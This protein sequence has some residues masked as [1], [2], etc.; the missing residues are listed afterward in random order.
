MHRSQ[1]GLL[2][3]TQ[4]R[5]AWQPEHRE[6]RVVVEQRLHHGGRLLL[7]VHDRVVESAVRLD[8]ADAGPGDARERIEGTDL[9]DHVLGQRLRLDVDEPAPEAGQVAITH[10]RTDGHVGGDGAV[11]DPTHDRGVTGMEATGHVGAGDH[12]EQ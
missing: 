2:G 9:I 5:G 8:V 12:V 10:L 11:T 4:P 3:P 1:P 6:R 7:V